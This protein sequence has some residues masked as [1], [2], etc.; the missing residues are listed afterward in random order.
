MSIL[1]SFISSPAILSPL[2]KEVL[3]CNAK[4]SRFYPPPILLL[5]CIYMLP[6]RSNHSQRSSSFRDPNLTGIDPAHLLLTYTRPLR[7]TISF[8]KLI[9]PSVY[10]GVPHFTIPHARTEVSS[11]LSWNSTPGI[12]TPQTGGNIQECIE[13]ARPME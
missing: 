13:D 7:T 12:V 1:Y 4:S 2:Y 11:S 9:L 5:S 6:A 10:R 8:I 3:L